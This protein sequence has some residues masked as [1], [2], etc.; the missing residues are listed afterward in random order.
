VKNLKSL[1]FLLLISLG[2]LLFTLPA[3]AADDN[4]MSG[5]FGTSNHFQPFINVDITWLDNLY[6]TTS[7]KKSDSISYIRPGI[8]IAFP[9][10]DQEILSLKTSSKSAGGVSLSRFNDNDTI[11]YQTYLFYSPEFEMYGKNTT[12]NEINH[13]AEGYF[14]YNFPG[15]L[16]FELMDQFI[17]NHDDLSIYDNALT[18]NNNYAATTLTMRATEKLMFRIDYSLYNVNYERVANY[19]DR[20]DNSTSAYVFFHVLPKTSL[21]FQYKFTDVNY[22]SHNT[23]NTLSI[24]STENSYLLGA[25]WNVTD[26]TTGTV[27][28][29]YHDKKF[30]LDS[31]HKAHIMNVEVNANYKMTAKTTISLTGKSE[32][33]ETDQD[34]AYYVE[35]NNVLAVYQH[36]L[37]DKLTAYLSLYYNHEDYGKLDRTDHTFDISPSLSYVYKKWLSLNVAYTFE[38]ADSTGS[39]AVEDYKSNTVLVSASASL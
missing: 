5:L 1:K 20:V 39:A 22:D 6:Q 27:K 18:Y 32:I 7:D 34:L 31:I 21:F 14:L 30:D 4:D 9:G 10:S 12:Y 25:R 38:N 24:D 28:A 37:T 3:W 29:G 11:R 26:K 19:N 17:A 36:A 15:G 2:S 23:G 16:S 8:W 33:S 35:S 13:K